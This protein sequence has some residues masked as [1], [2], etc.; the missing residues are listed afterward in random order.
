MCCWFCRASLWLYHFSDKQ[1]PLLCF[2]MANRFGSFK[3]SGRL[4]PSPHR[5]GFLSP[6]F[7]SGLLPF[8]NAKG[9]REWHVHPTPHISQPK[10]V[11]AASCW[12]SLK[13]P[14]WKKISWQPLYCCS[15]AVCGLLRTVRNTGYWAMC[16]F[17]L[18]GEWMDPGIPSGCLRFTL[19]APLALLSLHLCSSPPLPC[20]SALC[21]QPDLWASVP[22]MP[23]LPEA[24]VK[25]AS[26]SAQCFVIY[27]ELISTICLFPLDNTLRSNASYDIPI[28]SRQHRKGIIT[29]I[30]PTEEIAQVR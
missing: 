27:K 11:A 13:R 7:A 16:V 4:P 8:Q 28:S 22:G 18:K 2:F 3:S 15:Q 1:K 17:T 30:M 12:A 20:F 5:R 19:T 6:Q 9:L 10:L 29:V 14:G 24:T 21:P 26:L 25:A 23:G